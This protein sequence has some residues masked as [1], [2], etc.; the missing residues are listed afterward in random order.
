MKECE[1][2]FKKTVMKPQTFTLDS[3]RI[4]LSRYAIDRMR[5]DGEEHSYVPHSLVPVLDDNFWGDD[6]SE[7]DGVNDF[8]R[9]VGSEELDQR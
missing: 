3:S 8:V 1:F 7:P 4:N 6:A 5:A 9:H 2:T